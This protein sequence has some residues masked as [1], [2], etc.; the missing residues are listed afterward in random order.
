MQGICSSFFLLLSFSCFQVINFLKWKHHYLSKNIAIF[1]SNDDLFTQYLF[2]NEKRCHLMTFSWQFE[3]E[4]MRARGKRNREFRTLRFSRNRFMKLKIISQTSALFK[5]NNGTD[6]IM[7]RI[8]K[9]QF[10][11]KVILLH[12][13]FHPS[14]KRVPCAIYSFERTFSNK[15]RG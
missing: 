5:K 10:F 15:V 12:N 9:M 11:K 1:H 7:S 6:V 8:H 2:L 14:V 4:R 13:G 3:S